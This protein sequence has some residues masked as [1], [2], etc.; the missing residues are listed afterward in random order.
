MSGSKV[1]NSTK[2]LALI[3]KSG[4]GGGD[5]NDPSCP[6]PGVTGL[7]FF[8]LLPFSKWHKVY[9]K[10]KH[11]IKIN[12]YLFTYLEKIFQIAYMVSHWNMSFGHQEGD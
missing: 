6:E 1:I 10:I 3:S 8:L 11:K 9:Y 4:T 2:N 12:I 7:R 5:P